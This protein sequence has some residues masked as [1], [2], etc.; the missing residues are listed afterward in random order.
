MDAC[1]TSTT[2]AMRACDSPASLR[3]ESN[4]C[5][6]IAA[7]YRHDRQSSIDESIISGDTFPPM[8]SDFGKRLLKA[9]KMVGLSQ[10]KVAKAVGMT[11]PSYSHLESD[12]QSSA[13][14]PA[15]ARICRVS[16][17]WLAYGSG[18]MMLGL[19]ASTDALHLS[20]PA[21]EEPTPGAVELACLYDLIPV[22]DR[23]ARARAYNAASQAILDVLQDV[24]Q[25]PASAP[26]Q[27]KQAA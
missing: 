17:D 21:S 2:S 11:Q 5:Q 26:G 22:S 14:T 7:S 24:A 13:Y 27:K 19:P 3:S 6:F 12:G 20:I 1:L 8:Q 9:R 25:K 10:G 18:E 23:I 16:V 15:I 4:N